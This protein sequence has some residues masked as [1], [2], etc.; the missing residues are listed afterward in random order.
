MG[1]GPCM[2][3]PGINYLDTAQ[4][5]VPLSIVDQNLEQTV[6]RY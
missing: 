3:K 5:V 6:Y 2:A 4:E 1:N